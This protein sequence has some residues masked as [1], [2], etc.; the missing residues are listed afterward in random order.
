[1]NLNASDTHLKIK[2]LSTL[3]LSTK[4]KNQRLSKRQLSTAIRMPG[5]SDRVNADD[6][7]FS[8]RGSPLQPPLTHAEE[9]LDVVLTN[10][11]HLIEIMTCFSPQNYADRKINSPRS[12]QTR[13]ISSIF[14][15]L[16]D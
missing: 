5:D 9:T 13:E 7:E 16:C 10:K 1:M 14:L 2:I 15:T 11:P 4:I 12:M 8:A 3:R 6:I